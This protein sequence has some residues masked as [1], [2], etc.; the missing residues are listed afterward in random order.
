MPPRSVEPCVARVPPSDS[1]FRQITESIDSRKRGVATSNG[2]PR[3]WLNIRHLHFARGAVKSATAT[4]SAGGANILAR[5]EIR[6]AAWCV[7]LV[8]GWSRCCLARRSDR[9][10]GRATTST[11]APASDWPRRADGAL[12]GGIGEHRTAAVG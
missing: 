3:T 10:L 12:V 8:S 7:L 9:R 1:P 5:R 6:R 4:V 11:S 2:G